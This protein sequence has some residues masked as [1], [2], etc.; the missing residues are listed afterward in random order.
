MTGSIMLTA[1]GTGGHVLPAQV[2]AKELDR[3]GRSVEIVT[4]LRGE[5]YARRFPDQTIHCIAAET[6][7]GK[8]FIGKIV[9]ATL[10][11]QGTLQAFHL[12]RKI[13]PAAIV[14]FGG[15]TTLPTMLAAI[16]LS[17]PRMLHEQNAVFGRVN[18]LIAARVDAIAT[19][20]PV[21]K[22]LPEKDNQP[23]FVTGNP[24]RDE[25]RAIAGMPYENPGISRQFKL[26]IFG[27]SQ[28]SSRFSNVI[29]LALMA[30]PERHRR[31][32]FV[33]Q[34]CRQIDLEYVRNLY[35][36]NNILAETATFFEDLPDR[37]A[38]THLVI[39]RGGAGTVSELAVAGRPSVLVPYPHATE[40]HQT[41]NAEVLSSVGGAWVLAEPE[42]TVERLSQHITKLMDRPDLLKD[43][44]DAA[45][46]RGRPNAASLLADVVE[47]LAAYKLDGRLV[48]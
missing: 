46:G 1:G 29:P 7:G 48:S 27:G 34:Q 36:Q 2:L 26:L 8:G 24:V 22:L 42:M 39:A 11:T 23:K 32:L 18:R 19:S 21:T 16:A 25:V 44:A 14:G 45:L 15:Y 41:R 37:L 40:D 38:A 30:L 6:P 17:V 9:A 35:E 10:I 4:D 43:A 31:R 13:S 20:F 12:I 5:G 47:S 28:G 33:V 3:R